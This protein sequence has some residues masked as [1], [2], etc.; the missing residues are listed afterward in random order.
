[1]E[2]QRFGTLGIVPTILRKEQHRKLFP[3]RDITCWTS[4][5]P[6]GSKMVPFDRVVETAQYCCHL[7]WYPSFPFPSVISL[8]L[9]SWLIFCNCAP[10]QL[11]LLPVLLAMHMYSYSESC[12]SLSPD[13]RIFVCF[14]DV[15]EFRNFSVAP[16]LVTPYYSKFISFSKPQKAIEQWEKLTSLTKRL[17]KRA[18]LSS[19]SYRSTPQAHQTRPTFLNKDETRGFK[20][21]GYQ[22]SRLNSAIT[23][24]SA[25][26]YL[27][28]R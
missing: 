12:I 6:A 9:S 26:D 11:L 7:I 24:L 1:M 13:S 14:I 16:W 3:S 25:L 18:A 19:F 21:Q 27:G 23:V 28:L 20:N 15:S 4:K 22:R 2:F 10:Q 17:A 5:I 8:S